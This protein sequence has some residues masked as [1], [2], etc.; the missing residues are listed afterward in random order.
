MTTTSFSAS[1]SSS[2]C[3]TTGHTD[4]LG[5]KAF[6]EKLARWRAQTVAAQLIRDGVPANHV[7]IVADPEAFGNMSLGKEDASVVDRKVTIFF[8]R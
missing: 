5:D 2:A 7:Y 8:S 4:R 3:A 6:N 1:N